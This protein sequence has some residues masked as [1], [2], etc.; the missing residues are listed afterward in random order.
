ML[1]VSVALPLLVTRSVF[2]SAV[3]DKRFWPSRVFVSPLTVVLAVRLAE[4]VE[5]AEAEEAV[6]PPP[7]VPFCVVPV[8]LLCV[9]PALL[10]AFFPPPIPPVF[11][12]VTACRVVPSDLYSSFRIVPT[13]RSEREPVDVVPAPSTEMML[14]SLI[15]MVEVVPSE[16]KLPPM[17]PPLP[18]GACPEKSPEGA[19]DISPEVF[20]DGACPEG[21]VPESVP[22]GIEGGVFPEVSPEVFPDGACPDGAFPE[23]VPEGA[24]PDGAPDISP[25]GAV[26]EAPDILPPPPPI[27]PPWDI[28]P[29]SSV[30]FE[31]STAV[32]LPYLT[33]LL[34]EVV[35]DAVES[36]E[37]EEVAQP[38]VEEAI[39]TATEPTA[40]IFL[41]IFILLMQFLLR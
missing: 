25:E 22:E 33:L 37:D 28:V 1:L 5:E 11:I 7:V 6:V 3:A 26:P 13:A 4:V 8:A 38:I 31:P 36:V 23:S 27:P 39:R 2:S 15:V 32:I 41:K 19:P 18:D 30:I 14:S 21:A 34:S 20:P 12:T 29:I 9:V 10:S 40:I 35:P 16:V 24:W 17:P